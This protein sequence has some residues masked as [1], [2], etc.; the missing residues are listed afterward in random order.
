MTPKRRAWR[1]WQAAAGEWSGWGV[2]PTLLAPE[3]EQVDPVPAAASMGRDAAILRQHV[4]GAL[5]DAPPTLVLVDLEPTLGVHLAAELNAA[6]LAHPVLVLPRWP[7][8]H[9][10]LPVD[11]L[12]HALLGCALQLTRTP[13]RHVVFVLDGMRSS[14]IEDRAVDDARA[15]NRHRLSPADLPRATVL[16]AR[17]IQRVLKL[18]HR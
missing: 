5:Q 15:D 7:Y 18:A 17:G 4:S 16:R 10:V 2:C 9:A 13:C 8:A 1:R 11:T 14:A 6:G 3:V 12:L